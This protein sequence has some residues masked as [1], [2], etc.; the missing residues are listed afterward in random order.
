MARLWFPRRTLPVED[1]RHH[2]W[3]Y[4]IRLFYVISY[5]WITSIW[6]TGRLASDSGAAHRSAN[7]SQRRLEILE[8]SGYCKS[9]ST[10]GKITFSWSNRSNVSIFWTNVQTALLALARELGC[11]FTYTCVS[12]FVRWAYDTGGR[13][14]RN[15]CGWAS[16]VWWSN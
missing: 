3:S 11:K 5:P 15:T 9:R 6:N 13:G 12:S 1:G 8:I 14:V 4:Y 7:N 10:G 16:D 2:L